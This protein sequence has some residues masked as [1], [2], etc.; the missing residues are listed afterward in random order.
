MGLSA[1]EVV[2]LVRGREVSPVEVLES[3]ASRIE[4]L[5]PRLNA[6]VTL[7]PDAFERARELERAVMRG[8]P[9][10][11]L[12]GVPVT[13]KDTFE[14]AGLRS[15]S[16]SLLRAE[17]TPE[18]DAAAVARLRAG[19]AIILGKT[20]VPEMAATYE[21]ENP[22]FGRTNNPHDLGRTPGGS[23]GGEAAAVS[24]SLSAA[25]LG[26]DLTGSIRIPAHF[27]GIFGLKPTA[28]AIPGEGH[29]PQ[30]RGRLKEAAAFGPLARSVEDLAL[31]FEALAGLKAGSTLS[32]PCEV[33]PARVA[34]YVDDGVAPVS[35][36][37]RGAVERAAVAL[38]DA[39]FEVIAERPP[40]VDRG[41]NLWL[42]RLSP[43]VAESVRLV[44]RTPGDLN[45]AGSVVRVLLSRSEEARPMT[46]A[47]RLRIEEE[48]TRAR[49]ALLEWMTQTPLI[50]APV[51]ACAA[52]E[53]GT[54]KIRVEGLEM[55]VFRAFSYAQTFN[56]FN[57]PA[58]SIPAGRT[59]EGLP[60][61]VQLAGRPFHEK[62]ILRVA[63]VLEEALGGW[64]PPS[65]FASTKE[66]NPL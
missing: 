46:Q 31:L 60:L 7:A 21:S 49:R 41:H 40:S 18:H 42:E 30:M 43:D 50:L 10:G 34:W 20:N 32:E 47:E 8:D 12:C 45:R 26:S 35:E 36:E 65:D 44:Y 25:G 48:H 1:A 56:T 33:T 58:V 5:N 16:G 62:M 13:I 24:A 17:H 15:T 66:R 59:R 23:S 64:Q 27:C 28:G 4:E 39:G 52:F 54:R 63:R 9:P 6:I 38:A 61:G 57:L 22:V 53:H 37:I 2:R 11:A 19:G 55:S 14:T 29:C 3:Y 51:G